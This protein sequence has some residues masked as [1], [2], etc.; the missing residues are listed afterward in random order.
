MTIEE[1]KQLR[2]IG[3]VRICGRDGHITEV[4]FAG[5]P[6]PPPRQRTKDEER[7][8]EELLLYGSSR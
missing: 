3:A 5:A 7:A 1:I 4:V 2:D 8:E 6:E